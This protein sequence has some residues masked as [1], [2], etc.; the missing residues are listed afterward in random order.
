VLG[1]GFPDV[2]PQTGTSA[3]TV[4]D[5]DGVQIARLP[6]ARSIPL[7]YFRLEIHPQSINPSGK[8]VGSQGSHESNPTSI[9]DVHVRVGGYVAGT[10]TTSFEI[11]SD[12]VILDNTWIW[13]AD[14]GTD[15]SWTGNLSAHG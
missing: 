10:D 7:C 8:T 1:L 14:H 3:I 15:A 11:D 5:V 6:Q 4:A 2:I 12:N 9:S 13:R